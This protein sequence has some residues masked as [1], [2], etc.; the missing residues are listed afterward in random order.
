MGLIVL[1]AL[2]ALY[3]PLRKYVPNLMMAFF[4]SGFISRVLVGINLLPNNWEATKELTKSQELV[5]VILTISALA[6][7]VSAAIIDFE[8]LGKNSNDI[9]LR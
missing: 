1:V 8:N 4:Y 6:A 2:I 3:V 9:T 7:I 5:A